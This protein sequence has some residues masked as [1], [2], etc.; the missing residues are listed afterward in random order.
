MDD[1]TNLCVDSMSDSS[2]PS[3]KHSA[4]ELSEGTLNKGPQPEI[5]Y[6][7]AIAD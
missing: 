1:L 2:K 6:E 7:S 5:L 3:R 4:V